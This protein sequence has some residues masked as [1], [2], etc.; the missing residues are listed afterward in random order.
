[1]NPPAHR[2]ETASP[3]AGPGVEQR[4]SVL[5]AAHAAVGPGTR[6]RNPARRLRRI[7]EIMDRAWQR[8]Q[9]S[10]RVESRAAEWLLDNAYLIAE[11]IELAREALPS[12]FVRWLPQ[13]DSPAGERR[14]VVLAGE[15]LATEDGY[16]DPARLILDL[17]HYQKTTPLTTAELWALPG[18]LRLL[19]LDR[20][21]AEAAAL[22]GQSA[23]APSDSPATADPD[24][25]VRVGALVENLRGLAVQDWKTF[26]E[27]VSPV[28]SILREDPAGAYGGMDFETRDSYRKAVERVARSSG[29]AETDVA[30]TAVRLAAEAVREAG[31][32]GHIGFYLVDDGLRRLGTAG[33]RIPALWRLGHALRRVGPWLYT[34]GTMVVTLFLAG[35]IARPGL[36]EGPAPGA[37][38][39][40]LAL[41]PASAVAVA[42]VNWLATRWTKPRPLPKLR[43]ERVP[44]EC[45][46]TVV[47]PVL[48]T[49]ADE[50][51]Q[52]L[53]Q[54]ELNY[55]ANSGLG[56][57]FA[58][59]TDFADATA[60]QRPEDEDLLRRVCEGVRTL[61][62]RYGRPW[63]RHGDDTDLQEALPVSAP[64]ADSGDAGGPFLLLHRGRRWNAA[65]R[66]WMGWE[67]KR[68]KLMQFNRL[69]LGEQ[70]EFETL[71]G[72][73]SSL[74]NMRYAITLDA[75]TFLPPG[76]AAR[77][78]GV[79]AHP[80]NRPVF[81]R[82]GRVTRG[83]TVL[84]P[85]IEVVLLDGAVSAFARIFEGD[86]G[87]DLYSRAVS[88][89]YQDL[90][91]EGIYAGKGLYDI[92]AFDRSVRRRCP[93]NALLSH[94]LFEG[95]HG[96]A[97]LVSDVA[98]FEDYP[99]HLLSYMRRLH[100]W[101]RGDWQIAPWL[102]PRVRGAS[103]P[104]RNR[105]S[106]LD[107]WKIADNLRRSLVEPS[108]ALLLV[109]G[110]LFLPGSA[111]WWTGW[112]VAVPGLAFVLGTLSAARSRIRRPRRWVDLPAAAAAAWNE[113]VRWGLSLVFLPYHAF[114][115][116][117]AILRTLVRLR[118][119]RRLLEWTSAARVAH[120]VSV[121]AEGAV[122]RQMRFAPLIA[123]TLALVLLFVR[124]A[125]LPVAAPF[126]LAWLASPSVAWRISRPRARRRVVLSL[127]DRLEAR[128]LA[129]RTW[130]FF[131][132]VL[133]PE[134]HWLP[135]DHVQEEPT[136]RAARRTSPT[137]AG[138]AT[139]ATLAAW[140]LGYVSVSRLAALLL[141]AF[142]A[143]DRLER[144]RGHFLNWYATH[145]LETLRPRYVSTVDSGNLACALVAVARGSEAI[146]A[147]PMPRAQEI[148]GLR[149]TFAL[150]EDALG[151]PDIRAL[152]GCRELVEAVR[153]ALT[154][155][156]ASATDPAACRALTE[157]VEDRLPRLESLAADLAEAGAGLIDPNQI[158]WLRTTLARARQHAAVC[159]QDRLALMPWSELGRAP[160]RA[161]EPLPG[162]ALEAWQTLRL[163]L[164]GTAALQDIPAVVDGALVALGRLR[165]R[166]PDRPEPLAWATE[167]AERLEAATEN[168]R[169]L[170]A[171]FRSIA[172]RA[173]AFV[174]EMDFD[175]LYDRDRHLFRIG[176]D[177]DAGRP[178]RSYYDLLTSEARLASFLAI[179][180]GSVPPE[181]WLHL[182]RPFARSGRNPL[183]L[184]WG[185]T[186]FEYLMPSL[187]LRRPDS[188]LLAFACDAA[189]RE[190]R[191]HARRHHVPW[192]VSESA[193]HQVDRHGTYQ[194]RAWGVPTLALRRESAEHHVVAA[195]A[196]ALA[197][198]THGPDV[199]DNLRDIARMGG[200]GRYGMYEAI[201][202]GRNPGH[203]PGKGL[204]VRSYMA[205]HQAMILMAI[206]NLLNPDAMVD[207]FHADVR[208]AAV[209]HLVLERLPG[210]ARL[211]PPPATRVRE[212]ERYASAPLPELR[213]VAFDAER[214]QVQVLSNGRWSTLITDRGS[215]NARWRGHAL[216]RWRS[217]PMLDEF[218]TWLF[219]Q[220][221]DTGALWS[222][223][224]GPFEHRPQQYEVLFGP[225]RVEFRGAGNG[226]ASRLTV[227]VPPTAEIELRRLTLTNTGSRPR[228][229]AVTSFG[230]VTLGAHAEDVRHPAFSKLFV[231]SRL[232][233]ET[234]TLLFRRRQPED[235]SSAFL[236]HTVVRDRGATRLAGWETDRARFIG[237]GAS[238]RRP[239]G[240]EQGPASLSRTVGTTLDPVFALGIA[241][242][243]PPGEEATVTFLTGAG[244]TAGAVL[245]QLDPFRSA[246][247]VSWA[248]R[249]AREARAGELAALD[250]SADDATLAQLLLSALVYPFH[251][252]RS[253]PDE[254]AAPRQNALWGLGVSGDIPVLCARVTS[255]ESRGQL[256]RLLR[257][258]AYL[259]RQQVQA[260]LVVLAGDQVAGGYAEPLAGWLRPMVDA[261]HGPDAWHH[262]GGVF[263]VPLSRLGPSA[264]AA[265]EGSAAVA[266]DMEH[267]IGR[268]L[269]AVRA[270]PPRLP[271]FVPIPSAPLD[272][273]ATEAVPRAAGLLFDNGTGGFTD[274]G[275]EYVIRVEPDRP[276]TP[277]INVI[278]NPAFG[279]IVSEAGGGFT[280]ADD[281]GRRRLTPWR[282]DPVVDAPGEVI[283]LRDEE[284]GGI[285]SATPEP[286]PAG[287]P[288]EVRH[289]VGHSTFAH[290][291][292][293]LEQRLQIFVPIDAPVRIAR[294][295]VTNI[296]PRDRRLT[297]TYYAEWVLGAN[298][299]LTAPHVVT[300]MAPDA[301]AVLARQLFE[302]AGAGRVAFLAASER[303][304]GATADRAGFLGRGGLEDPAGLER[305]GLDEVF[306][307]G[308]DPCAAV[309]VHLDLRPGERRSVHF[310]LGE[311]ASRE[312]AIALIHSY[313]GE[314]AVDEAFAKVQRHWQE[315]LGVLQVRTPEPSMDLMLNRWLPVQALS[316]RLWARS[317][318]YQSS[319][320][321]GFR[322]QL[323]D[324]LAFLMTDPAIARRQIL[325]AA[326]R[327]FTEGDVLH[328]WHPDTTTGVRTRCSDDLLW[329]SFVTTAYVE[330][331]GDA[332]ILDEEIPFLTAP[333]LSA[334]ERER[335]AAF[336][337]SGGA[338]TLYE[339]C[340]RALA[341]GITQGEHGLPLMGAND[342]NDGFDKVGDEGRGESV[343]LGWFLYATLMGFAPLSE[344]V[345][346]GEAAAALRTEADRLRAALDTS[347]W[348]GEWYLRA[349]YDD[350]SRLGSATRS[351]ASI[352]SLS[353]SWAV[354]SG[355]APKERAAQ[356][357]RAVRGRLLD[358]EHRLIRLL[359]PPFDRGD[360]EPGYIKA[361]PPGVRENGAQYTHAAVW[362]AWAFAQIGEPADAEPF[363]GLLNPVLRARTP[364]DVATYRVEPYV[365]AADI[366]ATPPH[367]GR[368]GWTWYTGSASW[369]YRF[370]IECVLGVQRRG[371]VLYVDPR[372][373]ADWREFAIR[374]RTGD[375]E[376]RI[377][378]ENP[379]GCYDG[380]EEVRMD[381]EILPDIAIPLHNSGVH[382]V[383]VRLGE[384][385]A[386][387]PWSPVLW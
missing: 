149:D 76:A 13:L 74:R 261:L 180:L 66:C 337:S 215:G 329:L 81:G 236:A 269:D 84:Q 5:A 349:F 46:S 244:H 266:L 371:P 32:E 43:F 327:Q 200:L 135:V 207:R 39:L 275:R 158:A 3:D 148:D 366:Y 296:A 268:A 69:V 334:G 137:N 199:M 171:D 243:L 208:V 212:Q 142:D 234:N 105:L 130:A 138:L 229:L 71:V 293:G 14:I 190:Q 99:R 287:A 34:A 376:Y 307:S 227:C 374:Y 61:N 178:D 197:L 205:H 183:M 154:P 304:H 206:D 126:L 237:R 24:A 40:L 167:F 385:R 292:H 97:A 192:G 328:W 173:D 16:F 280:W 248:L 11:A 65:E 258:H 375:A 239:R 361:Y 166:L 58:L 339:H 353:Q 188:T 36:T 259:R 254:L 352:D 56:L 27:E 342:W 305:I 28:E 318:F 378:V 73:A 152:P 19:V 357:M 54:L 116:V 134:D 302:E 78:I 370:G 279:S 146:R 191:A 290:N 347:A 382:E 91:G 381:G 368:G 53:A 238:L 100:R 85:R 291:S 143:F 264:I 48:L 297:V 80:L 263:Q 177:V 387:R 102:L 160:P 68:G 6:R 231:E 103:G 356:A 332:A 156:P 211:E 124:P 364:D 157:L 262:T 218:G 133:G 20:L 31:P 267:D 51:D 150:V 145:D 96:R 47:V 380:V 221:L 121:A 299:E 89:V 1:V 384:R 15:L 344:R 317:A 182:A 45:P 320:A 77:L 333:P 331:T 312:E 276:P 194:Y 383:V 79:A 120:D 338:Y 377:R 272:P 131:E 42:F 223:T 257:I 222:P 41:V 64:A 335:Y 285:W 301:G 372:V 345:E 351:E 8:L 125:V 286:K 315:R 30:R 235:A 17:Q 104:L 169:R 321:Y 281:S 26:F 240:L 251:P 355:A 306:G 202:F 164:P 270:S 309:Q 52:I 82:G 186:M 129:R 303:L 127:E 365:V 277:W 38:S 341:R 187:L 228:R 295:D 314:A 284:T 249:E 114:V 23:A 386:T 83:Y 161:L 247:R 256:T 322:D 265:V 111:W 363:F 242:D 246:A 159:R 326:A 113:L 271:Q 241:L 324:V 230:E 33:F 106:L 282:N 274:D 325:D 308:L 340:R 163:A 174:V 108:V 112:A 170:T 101:I 283:Y 232:L 219:L 37:V 346:G 369:L 72:D 313:R 198:P 172:Q 181:H 250:M 225:H 90:F 4:F 25:G 330:A 155:L 162:D 29:R 7:R 119:R 210:E 217:D 289:G 288:Y 132:A 62:G 367:T 147:E 323:Q 118:T 260:D 140:D 35:I 107:R 95:I 10:G 316:C 252:V 12:S 2:A 358:E 60:E 75:D 311:A 226:I 139:T 59:L 115:N 294:L 359:E 179:A 98:V 63:N 354:L 213:P 350:G 298:R 209:E 44:A 49:T 93:Q 360:Q 278:A 86:R 175:F 348:D 50:I 201:D 55:H 343:W 193:F 214:P 88:D 189:V 273:L 310:L 195:Y 224:A 9:E 153:D 141:N 87:L 185:G 165:D 300:E 319:G 196:S 117:D 203:A 123:A 67:R 233:P 70:S 122:W 136:P 109:A 336:P 92:A 204:V 22:T 245:G 379:R 255:A 216:T 373:P 168:A 253:P 184:S 362:A 21:A 176:F 57:R 144:H 151:Q 110:W 94:D 18:L 220:D 128:R